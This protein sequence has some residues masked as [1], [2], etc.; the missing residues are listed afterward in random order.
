MAKFLPILVVLV[1]GG[2]SGFG[3]G[4]MTRGDGDDGHNRHSVADSVTLDDERE[5]AP[6][7]RD[8]DRAT[9]DIAAPPIDTD[10][11]SNVDVDIPTGGDGR[12]HGICKTDTGQP[13]SGVR[14]R[15]LPSGRPGDR[16]APVPHEADLEEYLKE[17]ARYYQ[18]STTLYGQAISDGAGRYEIT[19]LADHEFRL[20]AELDGYE[21]QPKNRRALR[22]DAEVNI[23][24]RA[25]LALEVAVQLPAGGQPREAR[26][27]A[28]AG[29]N[30]RSLE[31]TPDK[32][33]IELRPGVY[34]I[35]AIVGDD[36]RS[37]P[38]TVTVNADGSSEV[39]HLV[40]KG[41]IGIRGTVKA[42][43]G[44]TLT[45][46]IRYIAI[47]AD[48]T[49]DATLLQ[50]QGQH[51]GY[52]NDQF[53]ILDITPGRYLVGFGRSWNRMDVFTTVD[54]RDRIEQV[55]MELPP[56]D[57]DQIIVLYA[58]DEAGNAIPDLSFSIR[59]EHGNSTSSSG[60]SYTRRD[61][62]GHILFPGDRAL[63]VLTGESEGKVTLTASY[64]QMQKVIP[65]DPA[66]WNEINV[67]FDAPATLL[68]HLA[69]YVGSG[70]EGRVTLNLR[71]YTDGSSRSNR[72]VYHGRGGGGGK[73]DGEGVVGLGPV[74][75]GSYELM[76]MVQPSG[77]RSWGNNTV[78]T[79]V[80]EL[81]SGE[82]QASMTLPELYSLT[83]VIEGGK[84]NTRLQLRSTE[85][86][87]TRFSGRSAQLKKDGTATF[88][89]LRVGEYR[90][91]VRGGG[92]NGQMIVSVPAQAEVVFEPQVINAMEIYI[93]SDS[94][95]YAEIGLENGDLIIGLDGV[96]FEDQKH[97]RE[98]LANTRKSE[99][100]GTLLVWR[101][102][103]TVSVTF[104]PKKFWDH[105]KAGGSFNHV[106]RP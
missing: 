34:Q 88:E 54:V 102:S 32:S 19:G 97:M 79:Q 68:V 1:I 101:G 22:P 9:P 5:A 40:L 58:H 29:N 42:P 69:G 35:S 96:E 18:W 8:D 72:H 3:L 44:E 93:Q 64:G 98:L 38:K 77:S 47:S 11:F 15:A 7:R 41:R 76:L 56:I 91:Q 84:E 21:M 13:L 50:E 45:G 53:S 60:M 66:G 51:A 55:E 17:Q 27:H 100:Q 28:R 81:R 75:P 25:V 23:T 16:K 106:S 83:I 99:E 20:K 87:A 104:D 61:D 6:A 82:N 4:Y 2:V 62:G 14:V 52:H 67:S 78:D 103:S 74:Q 46:M 57:F 49:P 26:I 65:L 95:Y 86:R 12:I 36:L 80:L 39:V 33:A 30:T 59:V 85:G 90:V 73:P 43:A 71:T 89:G 24:G 63:D 105:Q 48:A 92:K 94:G 70:Y 31:W 10:A 37:K